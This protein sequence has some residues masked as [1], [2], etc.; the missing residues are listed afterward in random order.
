MIQK[1]NREIIDEGLSGN[2]VVILKSL[3]MRYKGQSY[4]LN[5]PFSDNI[6]KTF[7]NLHQTLY[8]YSNPNFAIEIV[9]LRM[10]AIGKIPKPDLIP[11]TRSNKNPV[12][13]LMGYQIIEFPTGEINTPIYN[14]E[15]LQYGNRLKGPA[16]IVRSDTTILL[17]QEDK[18]E[19]DPFQNTI[20][21]K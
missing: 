3:D 19:I 11:R 13:G 6:F 5:V 2:D 9:N 21:M 12:D 7:E 14:G 15:L 18:C 16:I 20:I 17:N 10:R 8:G 4:E 1:A